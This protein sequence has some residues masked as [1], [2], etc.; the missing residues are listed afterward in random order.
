MTK[1]TKRSPFLMVVLVLG[2]GVSAA[3]P[4]SDAKHY[5]M[6][7]QE[8]KHEATHSFH[9]DAEVIW[10][11]NQSY[12]S[13]MA[14]LQQAQW[15][16]AR[17]DFLQFEH[18]FEEALQTLDKVEETGFLVS[19]ALLIRA[20]ISLTIGALEEARMACQNLRVLVSVDTWATCLLEVEGRSGDLSQSYEALKRIAERNT[21]TSDDVTTWRYQ[22]LAEQ[23]QLLGHYN[24]ALQWLNGASYATQPVVAQ[25]QIL[26]IWF[27]QKRPELVVTVMPQCPKPDNLVPDSLIV[28]FARAE[29]EN[30]RQI[31]CWRSLASERIAIR[32]LR[33][34]RLHTADLAYYH[35]YVS[36]DAQAA[37]YWAELTVTVAREPF[38]YM[39]LEAAQELS[40]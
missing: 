2:C 21:D 1:F 31:T 8:G 12:L 9:Q 15:Y 23:A 29:R 24:E 39:L 26:D 27:K 7:V 6:L 3:A 20:R 17:A 34:D 28:R 22:I 18:R 37:V 32:E 36:G 40:P 30:N 14:P 16:L 5:A 10:Q 11:R 19:N 38:D 33:H 13:D 35:T 25:K 4:F